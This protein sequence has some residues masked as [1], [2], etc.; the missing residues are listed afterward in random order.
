MISKTVTRYYG[1]CPTHGTSV[2]F[3]CNGRYYCIAC[4][5]EWVARIN[6]GE[7]VITPT[8]LYKMDHRG[9][10]PEI[11]LRRI[12]TPKTPKAGEQCNGKCLNGKH[13]C[14]CHCGGRCHGAGTCYC[15]D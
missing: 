3:G 8:T 12:D 10:C 9:A 13:S 4:N 6:A 5:A 11:N 15:N 14:S 7:R 1:D 2:E